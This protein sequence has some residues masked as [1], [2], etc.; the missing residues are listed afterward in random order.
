MKIQPN[1]ATPQPIAHPK[2][3]PPFKP[4]ATLQKFKHLKG[5]WA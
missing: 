1:P 3:E 4:V 2:V 5:W